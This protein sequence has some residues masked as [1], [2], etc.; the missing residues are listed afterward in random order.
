LFESLHRDLDSRIDQFL[1]VAHLLPIAG[2]VWFQERLRLTAERAD[3]AT[4]EAA[5]LRRMI[6]AM[7]T[8]IASL[9][10]RAENLAQRENETRAELLNAH[11]ELIRQSD[12]F[13]ALTRDLVRERNDF[14]TRL[15]RIRYSLPG[16][17]LRMLRRVLA[18][19][20]RRSPG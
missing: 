8:Q 2:L 11:A 18:P 19:R 10:R 5:D 13:H 17:T 4:R 15:D 1:V 9:Y 12:E 7:D 16:R 20:T 3:A 14:Q 6:D